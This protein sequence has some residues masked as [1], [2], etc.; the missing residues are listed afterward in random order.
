M[1]EARSVELLAVAEE[2]GPQLV[3]LEPAPML[4]RM[5]G[6]YAELDEAFSWFL[7]QGR[8]DEALRM[9]LGLVDFWEYTGRIGDGRDRLDRA[10]SARDSQDGLRAL[11]LFRAGLLAFW[12]GDDVKARDLHEQSL[13]LAR[14]LG[15]PTATALA[16][17]G[18]ARVELRT[19]VDRARSL[20]QQ[21][22]DAVAGVDE[23]LGH[24]NAFHLLGV[25]AQMT[26]E[27]EDARK[28][29]RQRLELAKKMGSHKAA[30]AEAANLS[31]VERQLGNLAAARELAIEALTIASRRGDEWMIP[32]CLNGLAA[33]EVAD[34]QYERAASLLSAAERLMSEQGTAWPPD[35]APHFEHSKAEAAKA[36]AAADFERAW[37]LGQELT[38]AAAVTLALDPAHN[39]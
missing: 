1:N 3:G 39:H 24:S 28:W 19:G 29:M 12:Q 35:E 33:L 11:A 9:A 26:G 10:V 7:G 36:L 2:A 31:V 18:L 32:Y 6:L 13:E 23:Q 15:D 14:R 5:E 16:L 25:V 17:T 4:Q 8:P 38:Y 37:T 30:A 27:F 20:S 21:A 34:A 22:L